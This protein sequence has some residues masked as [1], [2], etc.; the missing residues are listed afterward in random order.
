MFYHYRIKFRLRVNVSLCTLVT[1]PV[2]CLPHEVE[3][4]K[5]TF[6]CSVNGIEV[7]GLEWKNID[8]CSRDMVRIGTLVIGDWG[9]GSG[10]WREVEIKEL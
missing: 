7:R 3:F 9:G 1:N 4:G 5:Q 10:L 8:V 6:K 2:R